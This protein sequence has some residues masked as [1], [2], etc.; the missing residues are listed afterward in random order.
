MTLTPSSPGSWSHAQVYL[1]LADL[2]P[3]TPWAFLGVTQSL[4]VVYLAAVPVDSWVDIECNVISLGSRIVVVT[5]D[6]Y[7]LES[8][9]GGRIRKTASGTHTKV[10]N[11]FASRM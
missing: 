2:E 1:H 11:S 8:E 4:S 7:L 9:D 6:M 3:T 5:C 10:D